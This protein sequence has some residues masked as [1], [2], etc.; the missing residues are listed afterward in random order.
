MSSRSSS[1]KSLPS[2]IDFFFR[3]RDN[4]ASS[5][6]S[7]IR[8]RS[9]SKRDSCSFIVLIFSSIARSCFCSASTWS[10]IVSV[11]SSVLPP[12]TPIWYESSPTAKIA[13]PSPDFISLI[14]IKASCA[15]TQTMALAKCPVATLSA[16]IATV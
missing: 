13:S 2:S 7:P 11:A 4:K 15:L 8:S 5:S 6:T 3:A 10:S 16:I 1:T 9:T 14:L 12:N